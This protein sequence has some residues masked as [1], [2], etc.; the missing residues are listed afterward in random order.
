MYACAKFVTSPAVVRQLLLFGNNL[1]T[2]D[3]LG[4]L[5]VPSFETILTFKEEKPKPNPFNFRLLTF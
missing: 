2:A 3:Y 1:K 5:R 4:W